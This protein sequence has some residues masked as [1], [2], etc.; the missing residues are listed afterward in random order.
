M[1]FRDMAN[2]LARMDLTPPPAIRSWLRRRKE[3]EHFRQLW[4]DVLGIEL[5][6]KGCGRITHMEPGNLHL[7]QPS[8]PSYNHCLFVHPPS[9]PPVG[10]IRFD[11]GFEWLHESA[12]GYLAQQ[13]EHALEVRR[14]DPFFDESDIQNVHVLADE[15]DVEPD[16]SPSEP[17]PAFARIHE[18]FDSS[19]VPEADDEPEAFGRR[20]AGARDRLATSPYDVERELVELLWVNDTHPDP[21]EL[22]L[23]LYGHL[24]WPLHATNVK[25]W[26]DRVRDVAEEREARHREIIDDRRR[27]LLCDSPDRIADVSLAAFDDRSRAVLEA[28]RRDAL[29]SGVDTLQPEDV[30]GIIM[31]LE[32]TPETDPPNSGPDD[33]EGQV[34]ERRRQRGKSEPLKTLDFGG[35][36]REC[37]AQLDCQGTDEQ[38]VDLAT[39]YR[40][41]AACC[42]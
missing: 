21:L 3:D 14:E 12:D 4:D 8:V 29:T 2:A 9:N 18:N 27:K 34:Y 35:R 24:E 31:Q 36:L 17:P 7:A 13:L 6:P 20:L 16:A 32:L 23:E 37:L 25:A 15:L 22:L 39:L 5:D 28:A 42:A 40:A 1:S 19:Q 41:L 11:H 10:F 33:V 38:L 26:I 30:L